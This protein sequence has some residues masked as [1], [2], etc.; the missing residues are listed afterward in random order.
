MRIPLSNDQTPRHGISPP[1]NLGTCMQTSMCPSRRKNG[2]GVVDANTTSNAN[3]SPNSSP[4]KCR[5]GPCKNRCC[6]PEAVV[7]GMPSGNA[8]VSACGCSGTTNGLNTV[9]IYRT[10]EVRLKHRHDGKRFSP[11]CKA[12]AVLST[13]ALIST[14]D[15]KGSILILGA[16]AANREI[17]SKAVNNPYELVTTQLKKGTVLQQMTCSATYHEHELLL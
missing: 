14:R 15:A 7:L 13:V 10:S 5:R 11:S 2:D 9:S 4:Y 3:G 8:C 16:L 1:H 12:T 6:V 17:I